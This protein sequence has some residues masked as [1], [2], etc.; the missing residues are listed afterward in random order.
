MRNATVLVTVAMDIEVDTNSPVKK[1]DDSVLESIRSEIARV[2]IDAMD[3]EDLQ[4]FGLGHYSLRL[5]VSNPR[6]A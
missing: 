2:L 5:S 3:M 6:L 4:E 1:L